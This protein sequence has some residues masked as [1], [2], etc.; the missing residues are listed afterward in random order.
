M[1]RPEWIAREAALWRK[2]M[3]PQTYRGMTEQAAVAKS[4]EI[5]DAWISH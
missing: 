1:T 3:D 5:Y 2:M 4:W